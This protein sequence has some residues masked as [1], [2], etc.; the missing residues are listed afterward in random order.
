MRVIG[1]CFVFILLCLQ[2]CNIYREF[3]GPPKIENVKVPPHVLNQLI[4][5][6]G[7]EDL[8]IELKKEI[9]DSGRG[10]NPEIDLLIRTVKSCHVCDD[11]LEIWEGPSIEVW[12]SG[13]PVHTSSGAKVRAK[14]EDTLFYSPNFEIKQTI[15]PFHFIALEKP[16]VDLRDNSSDNT[17][18][19][20]LDTGID[21]S[22]IKVKRVDRA[23]LT[24]GGFGWNF[25]D[26][27]SNVF[28]SH[29]HGTIVT[30][31]ILDYAGFK[32]VNI[33]PVKVLDGLGNGDLFDVLCGTAFAAKSGARF[34]NASLGFNF[35][36]EEP[37]MLLKSFLDKYLADTT[38]LIC[39]AGNKDDEAD[40]LMREIY[41]NGLSEKDLRNINVHRFYP[42]SM[43]FYNRNVVSITTVNKRATMVSSTQ[44]FS[45]TRVYCGVPADEGFLFSNPF[46]GDP[47]SG[48]SYATP[49][50]TGKLVNHLVNHGTVNLDNLYR[51]RC[52]LRPYIMNGRYL[53]R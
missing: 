23:C 46:G 15:K 17:L 44:N 22:V 21:P 43:S 52:L 34:I 42:A 31:Y 19:A 33:L 13:D 2:G 30:K 41:G 3:S 5:W 49:I 24:Q 12:M 38:Q 27:S 26:S 9:I 4:V 47:I 36:L 35:P 25:V 7:T 53:R 29:G 18:V 51:K 11:T 32:N 48:S 14:G 16:L 8:K 45:K 6:K 28:D 39:A 50:F 37:P 1:L 10:T 40:R 20:V